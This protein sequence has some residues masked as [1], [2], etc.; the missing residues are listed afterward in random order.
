MRTALLVVLLAVLTRSSAQAQSTTE[1]GVDAFLRG[2]YAQAAD[3]LKPIAERS[4]GSDD[5]ASFFMA[6]LY[7]AGLGVAPDPIR[8]CALYARVGG[9]LTRGG[10]FVHQALALV[11]SKSRSLGAERFAECT[12]RASIGWDHGFERETF[13]LGA[14]HW[15]TLDLRD[16]TIVYEGKE[17]RSPAFIV[18]NRWTR[19]GSIRHTELAAGPLR[20]TRRHFIEIFK[21]EPAQAQSW[22]LSWDVREVVRDTLVG[23]AREEIATFDGPEPPS[24]HAFDEPALTRLF[25]RDDGH[26]E[27]AVAGRAPRSGVADTDEDRIEQAEDRKREQSRA[28]A[29][30]AIDW[31]R[32]FD[33]HRRPS[34]AYADARSCGPAFAFGWSADRAEAITLRAP[35]LLTQG[36]RRFGIGAPSGALEVGLR[37]TN[38]PERVFGPCTD[39]GM[40]SGVERWHAT[41]GTV[42][43]DVSPR[44]VGG[45][46]ATRY[47]ATIRVEGA[48]FVSADGVRVQQTQPI[49]LTVFGQ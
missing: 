2:D 11:Q 43:I 1:D 4:R 25:V 42:V 24:N 30:R 36:S 9:P 20:L 38:E 45:H 35:D 21:W 18:T 44:G 7:D 33:V 32:T 28:A 31:R 29:E 39:V 46:M 27:W 47:H 17:T 41:K 5:V 12:W 37:L 10:P 48:E 19:V 8:A 34:L 6:A 16:A 3:I 23:V 22:V 40:A 14:G 15:V 49:V 13:A 26:V